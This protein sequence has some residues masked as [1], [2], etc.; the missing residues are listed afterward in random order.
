MILEDLEGETLA[1]CLQRTPKLPFNEARRIELA[2]LDALQQKHAENLLHGCVK[3][4]KDFFLTKEGE[5]KLLDSCAECA[6]MDEKAGRHEHGAFGLLYGG[7]NLSRCGIMR[8]V[9]GRLCGC[10]R[11]VSH[12]DGKNTR[13]SSREAQKGYA[14]PPRRQRPSG[15]E[16]P[17][18]RAQ[19]TE[20]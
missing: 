18:R 2:V 16:H 14:Q 10:R 7:G 13:R 5:I 9:D 20:R 4:D 3:P 19:R 11:D 1:A 17:Q 8:S 12:A 15:G 6:V